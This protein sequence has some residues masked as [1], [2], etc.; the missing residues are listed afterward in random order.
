MRA[1]LVVG[2]WVVGFRYFFFCVYI[3]SSSVCWV[4]VPVVL[5]VRIFF[6]DVYLFCSSVFFF[7]LLLLV[8][9]CLDE[10]FAVALGVNN[11]ECQY[12]LIV[13]DD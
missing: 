4:W 7:F 12:V 2:L 6:Y 9:T 3:F 1:E 13:V 5:C 11:T 8:G 10:A